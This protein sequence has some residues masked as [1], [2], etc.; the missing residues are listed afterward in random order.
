[1]TDPTTPHR[2]KGR[3]L[4][5]RLWT[6]GV[7]H[8]QLHRRDGGGVG[9]VAHGRGSCG[10]RG[11][12]T[13]SCYVGRPRERREWARY[14]EEELSRGQELTAETQTTMKTKS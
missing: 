5:Q 14:G 12:V 6:V 8:R 1:V 7:R 3:G 10:Q 13:M 2:E 11:G 4:R 9:Q